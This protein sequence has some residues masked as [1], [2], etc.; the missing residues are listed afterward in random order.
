MKRYEIENEYAYYCWAAKI[1]GV[2]GKY[3]FEREFVSQKDFNHSSSRRSYYDYYFYL[4]PNTIYQ[5]SRGAYGKERRWFIYSDENCETREIE[6]KE[7]LDF[8]EK[9]EKEGGENDK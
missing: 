1:K 6:K 8:F 7:V 9:R 2:G 4:E 3:G 5:I